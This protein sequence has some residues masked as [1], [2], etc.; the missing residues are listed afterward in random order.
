MLPRILAAVVAVTSIAACSASTE[1][2]PLR[3]STERAASADTADGA[4]ADSCIFTVS[5]KTV[6]A[7]DGGPVSGVVLLVVNDVANGANWA[8][9]DLIS[10]TITKVLAVTKAQEP[11]FQRIVIDASP[12][13]KCDGRRDV[14]GGTPCNPGSGGSCITYF[15][16]LP[17]APDPQPG[18]QSSQG[19]SPATSDCITP[20]LITTLAPA[21]VSY[22]RSCI[23]LTCG[24]DLCGTMAD[25]CGREITCGGCTGPTTCIENVCKNTH[26]PIGHRYCGDDGCVKGTVC[27]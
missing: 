10:G 27:P 1:V 11:A 8:V 2:E 16:P 13:G 22:V 20:D 25:G 6:T 14:T 24:G 17:Q 3:E 7:W 21:C 9:V 15:E 4:D 23:P 18:I 12:G 26:C 19:V 5:N